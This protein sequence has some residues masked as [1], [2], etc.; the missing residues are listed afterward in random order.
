M[1]FR[2]G[3]YNTSEY[4]KKTNEDENDYSDIKALY[5]VLNST[6][7]IANPSEWRTLLESKMNM[8]LYLKWLAANTVI[9]NWDTYGRMSHN[10]YLY[11]DP[12]SSKFVWIPWDNNEALQDGK[13]GGAISIDLSDVTGSWPLINYVTS[14]SYYYDIYKQNANEFVS[15]VF[16]S[17]K[18]NELYDYYS[19]L[20][21]E[22][23]LK[24]EPVYTFLKNSDDF[25]SAISQL[26]GQVS[27]RA[28]AVA[29]LK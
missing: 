20:I 28:I 16:T 6:T 15:T 23:V 25:D 11:N 1:L 29:S 7:R 10:Y 13:M 9:Q 14:D 2:S 24:E 8:E 3:T 12:E 5:D 21:R 18:M 22:S 4:Y 27:Q 17:S 19:S 26:K